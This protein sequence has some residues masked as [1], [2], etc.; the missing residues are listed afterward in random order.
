MATDWK[1]V[2]SVLEKHQNHLDKAS[3]AVLLV[4]EQLS[5]ISSSDSLKYVAQIQELERDLR[6]T[7]NRISLFL[8]NHCKEGCITK[9]WIARKDSISEQFAFVSNK[10][11]QVCGNIIKMIAYSDG[12]YFN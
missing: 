5:R 1:P 3:S 7:K 12:E 6:I 2:I 4:K 9:E 10:T 11:S 8:E